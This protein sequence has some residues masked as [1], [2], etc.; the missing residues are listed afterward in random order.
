MLGMC[1]GVLGLCWAVLGMSWAVLG[2]CWG[3]AEDGLG[4]CCC[5]LGGARTVLGMYWGSAGCLLGVLHCAGHTLRS[6][7]MMM[8]MQVLLGERSSLWEAFV[9]L[10]LHAL[11]VIH[12]ITASHLANAG[13][14]KGK[15]CQS[16][17][18]TGVTTL[19]DRP[20]YSVPHLPPS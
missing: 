6:G 8:M 3:C 10:K 1:W 14:C 7:L 4:L 15:T 19:C 13:P 17:I 20:G 12:L 18:A 2:L 16:P 5:V 11:P 9:K